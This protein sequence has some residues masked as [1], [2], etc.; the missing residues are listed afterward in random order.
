MVIC[1]DTNMKHLA[2]AQADD[3]CDEDTRLSLYAVHHTTDISQAELIHLLSSNLKWIFYQI[4][5]EIDW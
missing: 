5:L 3:A 4:S 2:L 1:V